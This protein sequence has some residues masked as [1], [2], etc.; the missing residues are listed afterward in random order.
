MRKGIVF[1]LL[2]V[3]GQAQAALDL[4][5]FIA[6]VRGKHKGLKAIEISREAAE[7]R[8]QAGDMPL[9]PT[10]NLSG[11]QVRDQKQPNFL[12]ATEAQTD[13]YSLGLTKKFSTGTSVTL[14]ATSL[15]AVNEMDPASP[16]LGL[17][18]EYS[19]TTTGVSISQSLWKDAF[20]RGTRLRRQK[21]LYSSM[22][23]KNSLNMEERNLLIEAESL[24]WDYLYLKEESAQR[25]ASLKRAQKIEKW[26]RRRVAN[27]IGDKADLLQS[28]AL[29][30]SRQLQL[31]ITRDEWT[32]NQK[33]IRELLELG[34]NEPLPILDGRI[35]LERNIKD[36]FRGKKR[37]IRLDAYLSEIDAKTKAAISEEVQDRNR[38]DL[39][40]TG[41]YI[42]NSYESVIDP[43]EN[44]KNDPTTTVGLTWSYTFGSDVKDAALSAARRDAEAAKLR[45]QKKRSESELAWQEL[46]RRNDELTKKIEAARVI[47]RYQTD[48]AQAEEDKLEKGRSITSNVIQSEQDAAEA[49]LSLTKLM[50]EQRKLEAQ[51]Q[52]FIV[53]DEL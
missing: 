44:T 38:A 3:A 49:E 31:L 23:E 33:K 25:E 26:M 24:Y 52:L 37:V 35:D 11:T 34:E 18:G 27:G 39:S 12:G 41:S 7:D 8:R 21:E 4:H 14:S 1:V 46:L 51:S 53:A 47:S 43:T 20:G 42:S 17:F 2:I 5:E 45:S 10:L 6:K 50:A 13:S 48:R 29:L 19:Q 28:Q 16:F 30:A 22:A 36:L 9:V 15:N 40:L 32:A